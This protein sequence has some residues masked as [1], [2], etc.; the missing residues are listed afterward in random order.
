MDADLK[1]SDR[2][3]L[4][5]KRAIGATAPPEPARDAPGLKRDEALK[6]EERPQSAV[7][8]GSCTTIP[9]DAGGGSIISGVA[10]KASLAVRRS[11]RAPRR[12]AEPLTDL[13]GNRMAEAV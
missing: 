5:Q 4:Q 10:A 7:A 8:A 3:A 11:V 12:G 2:G 6:I 13:Q 9:G 1:P